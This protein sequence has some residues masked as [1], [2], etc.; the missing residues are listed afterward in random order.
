MLVAKFRKEKK[1]ENNP[2][3]FTSKDLH[4]AIQRYSSPNPEPA[5]RKTKIATI[6]EISIIPKG[7]MIR[8]KGSKYGS[9]ILAKNCPT[10]DSRALG[11][12]E[13]KI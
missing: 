3:P 4:Y 12:H 2:T 7:G 6:G 11:N 5:K 8:R 13:S 1:G 10:T 9:H